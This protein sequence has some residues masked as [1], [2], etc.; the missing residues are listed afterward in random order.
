MQ[1]QKYSDAAQEAYKEIA[2]YQK[3]TKHIPKTGRAWLDN[4]FPVV[5]G[6][7]VTIAG[8]SGVGKSYEWAIIRNNLL[9]RELNPGSDRYVILD[10]SLEMKVRSLL[11]REL[12]R[13][14]KKKKVDILT[15][16]LTEEEFIFSQEYFKSID[17]NRVFINQ[18]SITPESFL[19][20][21]RE[22]LNLHRDKDSVFISI[23]HI[24]L[25]KD[26]RGGGKNATIESLIENVNT[27]KMQ[28]NNVTFFL[29]SQTNGDNLK[30]VKEKDRMSQP[31]DSDLYYSNFTFQVSDYVYVVT[32][33]YIMG[34]SE[35]SKVDATR[36][37]HLED[38]FIKVDNKNKTSLET[39][40][41]MYYHILKLREAEKG[42]IDIYAED[43]NMKG[44]NEERS[45]RK[46]TRIKEENVSF[47]TAPTFDKSQLI[48]MQNIVNNTTLNNLQGFSFEDESFEELF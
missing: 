23:D 35:Y 14:L 36:Y 4:E 44:L 10:I 2:L 29:L 34:I 16:P 5:N 1:I 27:L 42:F 7:V 3:G 43:L 12:S 13:K 18:E 11:L 21:C 25:V 38:Y 47:D 9:N 32:S 33:P 8:G 6:S 24:A 39:Y 37:A 26:G 28:F 19:A 40:G 45:K 22:F 48:D 15:A 31:Q 20:G 41:V 17:D 46:E 30:R